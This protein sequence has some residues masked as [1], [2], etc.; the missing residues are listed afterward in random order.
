M[1]E[2]LHLWRKLR[3]PRCSL[4]YLPSPFNPQNSQGLELPSPNT[5]SILSLWE[6]LKLKRIISLICRS[7]RWVRPGTSEGT[8]FTS[9]DLISSMN[10]GSHSKQPLTPWKAARDRGRSR[11]SRRSP[12]SLPLPPLPQD[13]VA[14]ATSSP[15]SLSFKTPGMRAL[16]W[17]VWL[18]L[19]LCFHPTSRQSHFSKDL[20]FSDFYPSF[21][22]AGTASW[23]A[24]T[25]VLSV[26]HTE[27]ERS[28]VLTQAE[29]RAQRYLRKS[30]QLF[31]L[32]VFLVNSHTPAGHWSSI[33]IAVDVGR[34]LLGL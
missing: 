14:L 11:S 7:S 5:R 31:V 21:Q 2:Y 25:W 24:D 32:L 15:S 29:F 1:G 34:D 27:R 3:G 23:G 8:S 10:L 9:K 20:Q 18:H 4:P 6:T 19:P 33:S 30:L 12:I 13:Q 26:E 16:S 22:R 28:L 17:V